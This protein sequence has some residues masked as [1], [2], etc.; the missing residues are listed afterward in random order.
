M[1]KKII[2]QKCGFNFIYFGLYFVVL[3]ISLII[4]YTNIF[5]SEEE[6]QESMPYH[7]ASSRMLL[8][9]LSILSNFLAIIPI[10][11]RKKY[12]KKK[13]DK[14]SDISNLNIEDINDKNQEKLIYNNASEIE[15]NKKIKK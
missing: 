14:E 7:R 9:L 10:Y 15:K 4:N 3:F 12:I 5:S 11:I 8:T 13:Q 6:I 2:F 1:D